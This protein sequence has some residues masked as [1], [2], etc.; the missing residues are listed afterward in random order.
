MLMNILTHH[1]KHLGI[2]SLVSF[3]LS[4]EEQYAK[5][6]EDEARDETGG[7]EDFC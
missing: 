2:K 1:V 4:L 5:A 7:F 6:T 3:S